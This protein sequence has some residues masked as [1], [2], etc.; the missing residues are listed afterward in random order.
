MFFLALDRRHCVAPISQRFFLWHVAKLW[1]TWGFCGVFWQARGHGMLYLS[2]KMFIN[3]LRQVST[4]TFSKRIFTLSSTNQTCVSGFFEPS[5]SYCISIFA[6]LCQLALTRC[7]VTLGNRR[8]LHLQLNLGEFWTGVRDSCKVVVPLNAL[9]LDS[10]AWH[11]PCVHRRG[12][13]QYLVPG[14][15]QRC[16]VDLHIQSRGWLL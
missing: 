14:T 10:L 4:F 3:H 15:F 1:C 12:P 13:S 8:R 9:D 7:Y 2:L 6:W 16:V 5:S 11:L